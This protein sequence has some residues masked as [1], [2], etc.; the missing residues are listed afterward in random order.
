MI[1]ESTR[2]SRYQIQLRITESTELRVKIRRDVIGIRNEETM[3]IYFNRNTL[4]K[5]VRVPSVTQKRHYNA[6]WPDQGM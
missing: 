3:V 5:S 2:W 4:L 6:A 1:R